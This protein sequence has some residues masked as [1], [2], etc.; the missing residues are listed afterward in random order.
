MEYHKIVKI[1]KFEISKLI[2]PLIK[3]NIAYYEVMWKR[4][5]EPQQLNQEKYY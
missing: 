2:K 5:N 4:F 1:E 3:D